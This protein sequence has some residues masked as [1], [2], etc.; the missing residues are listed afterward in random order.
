MRNCVVQQCPMDVIAQ[1]FPPLLVLIGRIGVNRGTISIQTALQDR[2]HLHSAS[3]KSRLYPG[4]RCRLPRQQHALH[5]CTTTPT[6]AIG[7]L[8]GCL[9]VIG[10][11]ALCDSSPNLTIMDAMQDQLNRWP[12]P[13]TATSKRPT[14]NATAAAVVVRNHQDTSLAQVKRSRFDR[15]TSLVDRRFFAFA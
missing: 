14:A 10:A 1:K 7:R 9:S 11:Y 13:G 15:H 4:H 6:T 5:R 8:A 12:V 3:A 2:C